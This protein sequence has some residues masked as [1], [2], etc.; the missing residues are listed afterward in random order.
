MPTG[1]VP[2]VVGGG[3]TWARRCSSSRV[4]G[5]FFTGSLRHRREGSPRRA[6]PALMRVQLELG[7]KDPVYVVRRRRRREAAAGPGRRRVLQHRP[8]LLLG[9]A[10]LRARAH[11]TIAF[12]DAFVAEVAGFE[13]GDPLDDDTYIGPLTR[14]P[15]LEVLEAQVADAMAQGRALLLG[16]KRA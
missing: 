6:A 1:R 11:R 2:A 13:V 8:E 7:G 12:V 14:A 16:G 3:A 10:H 15:Q 4:D 5:V 9:R